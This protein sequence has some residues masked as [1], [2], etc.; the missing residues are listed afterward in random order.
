M[1]LSSTKMAAI[2]SGGDELNRQVGIPAIYQKTEKT[3]WAE[4]TNVVFNN[5][6]YFGYFS[7]YTRWSTFKIEWCYHS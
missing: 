2:L 4:L 1:K 6:F 3:G 5:I 7:F